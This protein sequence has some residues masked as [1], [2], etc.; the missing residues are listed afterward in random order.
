[1]SFGIDVNVNK[2]FKVKADYDS[3]FG[4][5]ADVPESVRHFP[6]VERLIDL[7]KNRY[8]WEMEKI[9]VDRYYIQTVYACRYTSNRKNGEVEWEPIEHIGNAIVSGRWVVKRTSGGSVQVK[10][11]T[12]ARITVPLPSLLRIFLAALIES[13]FKTLIDRYIANLRETFELLPSKKVRTV[14]SSAL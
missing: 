2:S 10:L 14:A 11:I 13:E 7:G 1:M 12:T 6:K 9:G 3:V 4:L 8:Q 5:L